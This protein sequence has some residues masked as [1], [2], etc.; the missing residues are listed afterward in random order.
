[1]GVNGS[2]PAC[3]SLG[4]FMSAEKFRKYIGFERDDIGFGRELWMI[5]LSSHRE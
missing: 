3:F 2:F 4:S 5:P 1:M